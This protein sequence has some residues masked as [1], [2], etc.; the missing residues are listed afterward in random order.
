VTIISGY[1]LNA[2]ISTQITMMDAQAAVKLKM[3]GIVYIREVI[4]QIQLIHLVTILLVPMIA[5]RFVV[6]TMTLK[7]L[8][9][10]MGTRIA[11][12]D[13]VLPVKLRRAG[14]VLEVVPLG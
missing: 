13:A 2:K 11:M 14:I 3:A 12:M 4:P 10:K 7:L 5:M 6:I 1:H 8:V 9:V